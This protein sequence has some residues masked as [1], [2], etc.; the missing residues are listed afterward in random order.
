MA[1]LGGGIFLGFFALAL[2]VVLEGGSFG[3]LIAPSPFLL[4]VVGCFGGTMIGYDMADVKRVP[5]A[6]KAA[7]GGKVP[8][9]SELITQFGR[10]A[11]RARQEGTLALESEL[12]NCG[13]TFMKAGLQLVVDGVDGDHVK[14]VLE[15]ELV[16]VKERHHAMIKFFATMG[17]YAPTFGLM[18]TIIGLTS[19]LTNLSDPEQLGHGMSLGLLG[20]LYGVIFANLVFLPI[21]AR[22]E[23]FHQMELEV[24]ELTVEGILAL[25]EGVSA[26]LLVER[27][28]ARLSPDQRVGHA[29][30]KS[31]GARPAAASAEREVA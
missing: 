14:E 13:D 10:M 26:R 25:R 11:E 2:A 9:A 7:M 21:S 28:E 31:G 19:V 24:R 22:L 18:G 1:T 29:Q 4:V 23:R 17:G 5:K 30:R 20:T 27:L 8:D 6:I 12:A 15:T 3:G 16:A